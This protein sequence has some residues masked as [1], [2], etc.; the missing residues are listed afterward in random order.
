MNFISVDLKNTFWIPE[1]LK[2]HRKQKKPSKVHETTQEGFKNVEKR[3]Y[4]S[5]IAP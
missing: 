4:S 1:L 5:E 2:L 3:T